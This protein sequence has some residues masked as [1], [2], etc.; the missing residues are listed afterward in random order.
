MTTHKIEPHRITKP[1]QLLAAWIIGLI[2]T[3]SIFLYT[4]VSFQS[5]TWERGALVIA[6]I[7][8]VPGFLFALFLLQ[9]KF[10]AELQEDTFYN[11]YINKKTAVPQ[12]VE[13]DAIQDAR[14]DELEKMLR[15][16]HPVSPVEHITVG[17][18]QSDWDVWPVAV[19]FQHPQYLKIREALR[20]E[21]ISVSSVFGNDLNSNVPSKWII[22]INP[23]IPFQMKTQLLKALIPFNFDGFELHV[24]VRE[25]DENEDVYIGGYGIGD[26]C[27]IDEEF[28]LLIARDIEEVDFS[29]YYRG[30]RLCAEK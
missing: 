8:N 25:V 10:R 11:E 23:A 1:I 4:A 30:R 22:A 27:E 24:P 9:T 13:R 6:S 7:L 16:L 20:A 19:N 2:L 14:I 21:S 29:N 28:K 18:T 17:A 12:R 26:Y 3:D 5:G 15:R